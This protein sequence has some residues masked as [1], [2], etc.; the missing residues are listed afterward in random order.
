M[1]PTSE[2]VLTS[3][4]QVG[5]VVFRS[6]A[7]DEEVEDPTWRVLVVEDLE[8]GETVVVEQ[9]PSDVGEALMPYPVEEDCWSPDGRFLVVIRTRDVLPGGETG[10][11]SFEFLDVEFGSWVCFR[12]GLSFASADN[13][14]GWDPSRP[15]TMLIVSEFG[16]VMPA[17]PE[18]RM[19]SFGEARTS[20]VSEG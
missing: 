5:R 14:L 17:M 15:H 2:F 10:R 20:H 4:R 7:F 19:V 11:H 8:S 3:P 13:F 12:A 16:Q 18:V 6:P 1:S 9:I